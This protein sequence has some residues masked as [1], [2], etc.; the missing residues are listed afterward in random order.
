VNRFRSLTS[1]RRRA[2]GGGT[3]RAR[4]LVGA[5][6]A[7][8]LATTACSAATATTTTTTKTTQ[9]T[10]ASSAPVTRAHIAGYVTIDGK[11]VAIPDE[12]D[13]PIRPVEDVGEQV[14]ITPKAIEPG[15]LW[16]QVKYR[17][18]FTNLTSVPQQLRFVNDGGWRSP[19]IPPGGTW[20]YTPIFGISY[21]YV[22]STGLHARFQASAPLAGNP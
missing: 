8:W 19:I 5:A 7:I 9:T 18:T 16:C 20:H 1:A 10:P 3:L 14:I 22:T 21:Y 6:A 17:L 15:L 12:V 13:Q 4:S 11:K 2:A